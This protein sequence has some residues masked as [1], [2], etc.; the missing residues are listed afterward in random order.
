MKTT[1]TIIILC[2]FDDL[3]SINR[4]KAFVGL[5]YPS[6][7]GMLFK[8]KKCHVPLL[9]VILSSVICFLRVKLC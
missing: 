9:S 2:D 3:P 8:A 5:I 6:S 1:I 4:E 7:V